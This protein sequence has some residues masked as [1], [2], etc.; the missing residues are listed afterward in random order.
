MSD[1]ATQPL[2]F[3]KV[4]PIPKTQQEVVIYF[5]EPVADVVTEELEEGEEREPATEKDTILEETTEAPRAKTIIKDKR[6][7]ATIDRAAVLNRLRENNTFNV[8]KANEIIGERERITTPLGEPEIRVKKLEK[9]VVLNEANNEVRLISEQPEET[10]V[11]EDDLSELNDILDESKKPTETVAVT[12]VETVAE[13]TKKIRKPRLKKP[14]GPEID[15][16]NIDLTTASIRDKLMSERLPKQTEKVIVKAP[17]YYMNNRKIAVQKLNDL[18]QPYRR[19]IMANESNIS[20]DSRSAGAEFELLTHQKIVRDYLNLYTPYRGLLLYHGLGAGKCHS[21]NTPIMMS[22]GTCKMVQDILEGD[23]LMGDDSRPRTV[24]SLARGRDKMYDIIP[25]KGEKYTVNQE[26]ILCLRASGFPKLS[27]NN[28]RANTNYN[29]Q[30]IE[31]NDFC[32][33]TFTFNAINEMDKKAEAGAFFENIQN[34]KE[35]FDN[36]LEIAVKDYLKLSDKKKSFLKG[37][38]VAVD[39][40]EKE[41]PVDPYMIGYWLGDGTGRGAEITCQDS[42]VLHYFAKNLSDLGLSLNYR[43]GYT[44]GISGNGKHNNNQFLNV[45]KDQNMVNNKHIPLIYKCNSRENRMKLLAGLLDSDGHLNTNGGFE[46]T[47]KDETLMNDVVFL[48]RSLG[49]SC[50]KHEKKTSWTYNGEKKEGMAWRIQINGNGVENIPTQIPRKR[51]APRKQIKDVLVTG[52]TVEYVGENEYY[53][54]M[55]DGNCRYLIGD[56]TVTHNTCTSIAIAEG[57]K[58]DK[59]IYVLTPASL[60]MNFFSELKKCGDHLYKKNQFW[61]FVS[62]DGKP[63]Y[64]G[65]LAKSLSLTTEYIREHN[66]AWLVNIEKE[67]NFTEKT[68]EEQKEIDEQLNHMIRSKYVDINY[69]GLNKNIFNKLTNN[70]TINPFDNAVVLIDEAHN[71]VSRIVNKIKK[72]TAISYMLYDLLMNATNARIVLLTGTP[73][74]NY[75]NEIGILFNI[76]RGY[77]KTW[78]LSVNVKTSDKINTDTILDMFDKEGLKTHDYLEYSGNKLTITRNP[79]GF[80][81]TKKRGIAKGTKRAVKTGGGI[82]GLFGGYTYNTNKTKTKKRKPSGDTI[83]DNKT[84]D[85]LVG[86]GDTMDKYNGVKLDEMG[87]MSDADFQN[88]V[89]RILTKH[90]LEV[91]KGTIEVKKYK[92]LPDDSQAFLDMFVNTDNGDV[93]NLDVF[94]RRI[95]GLTSYFRSAQEQLLPRFVKTA[96][97]EIFHIMK[98]EMTPYQFG[99]Y[100]KIRKVEAEQEKK[101]RKN[102]KKAQNNPDND[103]YKISSTYRIFSRAACNFAFPPGIDRPLPDNSSNKEIDENEFNATPL[104]ERQ[105]AD[106]YLDEEDIEEEK[107]EGA[108]TE[109]VTYQKRIEAALD[110][111]KFNPEVPRET[112]YLRKEELGEYSPKFVQVLENIQSEENQGLHLIYT[113]FRTIEGIGI[114]KLILEANGFAEF[115]IKKVS[116]NWEIVEDAKDAGKPKFVLYTGTEGA[117]EKE[118]VRNIYNSTWDFVPPNIATRLREQGENNFYGDIIKVFMITS[119]GAE[120]INLKNTRFVHVIEPYWH[121]VRIEQVIGRARRICSHQD[122]PENLRTVKVFLYISTLSEEQKTSEKNIELRIRDISKLD[123]KTPVTTDEALFETAS[124]KDKI[125]RQILKAVKESAVD[126]SLYSTKNKDEPLVCYG[127]GKI[128]SNQFGSHPS[129]EQDR[130]EKKDLNVKTISWQ[131]RKFAYKGKDYALNEDTNEVFDYDSYLLS[132]ESGA[133]LVLLGHLVRSGKGYKMELL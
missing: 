68:A 129:F 13:P 83:K 12:E 73:I 72:P 105:S 115:K 63:E 109:T 130:G 28:H 95:L 85:Y 55:L 4:K 131:A 37:Y 98:T 33:K 54:F 56:F 75:P 89:I 25:V 53:G 122:L 62:I 59:Q 133:E 49:F 40:E 82:G 27:R 87:N 9:R 23:F 47:Q 45:L 90:N 24:L 11:D 74:I 57:M 104:T 66:G 6:K 18:F 8:K 101:N 17:T 2:E 99:I 126:C 41:L 121:M 42:T 96:E 22:N 39:F 91:P 120:G 84:E 88:T 43:S 113:Q 67:P 10:V 123:A 19:E 102:Q 32:S 86:G 29:V 48:A 65:I 69:N 79:F 93:K 116:D 128:E 114:L 21:L 70:N 111:L 46:F 117:E 107:A 30:W 94:Q 64:V 92:A 44:Y 7:Y 97:D 76:L 61:E 52:I 50:Y 100:E 106:Q 35:T 14:T 38:K 78:T 132:R 60:K 31:N 34:G 51:A 5:N 71:F 77:I 1:R 58:T 103:L 112:E 3:L 108:E 15:L 125:N 124:L 36:V 20:C 26:H 127:F 119:S 81:N 80:V 110:K 16:I 118:I